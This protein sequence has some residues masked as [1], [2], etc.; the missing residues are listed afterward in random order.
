MQS[1][2]LVNFSHSGILHTIQNIITTTCII[3]N[4]YCDETSYEAERGQYKSQTRK[5]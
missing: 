5:C 4:L 1:P 2:P 3:I